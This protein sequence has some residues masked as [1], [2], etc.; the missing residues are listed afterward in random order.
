MRFGKSGRA[1]INQ[2]HP[3]TFWQQATVQRDGREQLLVFG[4]GLLRPAKTSNSAL[5]DNT[6]TNSQQE[7]QLAIQE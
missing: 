2:T 5:R 4:C 7:R 3:P 6:R 1:E